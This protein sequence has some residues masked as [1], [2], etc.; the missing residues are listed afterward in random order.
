MSHTNTYVVES[1]RNKINKVAIVSSGT[2]RSAVMKFLFHTYYTAN[3]D[4]LEKL[5]SSRPDGKYIV[6]YKVEDA[7]G[8]FIVSV[9][10]ININEDYIPIAWYPP[11]IKD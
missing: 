4:S 1:T 6:N 8:E 9:T 5:S 3:T 2:S 10:K 7:D 11:T